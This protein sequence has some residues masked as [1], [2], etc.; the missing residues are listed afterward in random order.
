MKLLEKSPLTTG[1][2]EGSEEET[3]RRWIWTARRPSRCIISF[4]AGGRKLEDA[5]SMVRNVTARLAEKPL[6]VSDEL[7]Q[8]ASVSAEAYHATQYTGCRQTRQTKKTRDI[9]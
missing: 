6:F 7:V 3:G 8:Y 4:H 1:K 2:D 5:M 9:N